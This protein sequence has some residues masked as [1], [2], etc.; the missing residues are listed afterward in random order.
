MDF[1]IQKAVIA[2]IPAIT[3]LFNNAIKKTAK[4]EYNQAQISAWAS[5]SKNLEM[6]AHKITNNYFILIKKDTTLVGFGSLDKNYVDLLY[7]HH[8]YQRQGIASLIYTTLKT[9]A[10]KLGFTNLQTHASKTALPFFKQKGFK[11]IKEHKVVREQVE[12]INFEM[13]EN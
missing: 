8:H 11:I 2:N 13:T 3:Q 9:E 4:K 7:V 12:I 10:T 6:W 5:S 1:K